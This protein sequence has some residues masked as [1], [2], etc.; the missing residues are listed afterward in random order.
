MEK[1]N[2]EPRYYR[3]TVII[4]A[5]VY[6]KILLE[7]L[8]VCGKEAYTLSE[9]KKKCGEFLKS[10][11]NFEKYDIN[12]EQVKKDFKLVSMPC[13][14]LLNADKNRNDGKRF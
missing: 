11:I 9:I 2:I 1:V 10:Q 3:I 8:F 7:E 5:E 4:K 6:N 14:F 12:P 13:N